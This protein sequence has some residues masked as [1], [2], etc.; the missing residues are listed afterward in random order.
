MQ[1]YASPANG[2]IDAFF[3]SLSIF[4][5][6]DITM[7]VKFQQMSASKPPFH[8]TCQR[9]YNNLARNPYE[10]IRKSLSMLKYRAKSTAADALSG[11]CKR[12]TRNFP[13]R[14]PAMEGLFTLMKKPLPRLFDDFPLYMRWE[15]LYAI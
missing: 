9:G 8:T 3:Q 10:I 2:A 15:S 5:K 11:F 6:E 13:I 12:P 4:W 14:R 1:K 7:Y